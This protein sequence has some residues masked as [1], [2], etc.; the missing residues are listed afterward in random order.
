[1]RSAGPFGL[2]A[3]V[4][5]I[6]LKRQAPVVPNIRPVKAVALRFLNDRE[7]RSGL[8]IERYQGDGTEFDSLKEY[9]TGDDRRAIDW[10]ATARHRKL[11][12]RQNRAERNHQVMIAVDT[13]RLMCEP[14]AGIPKV[15][16]AVNAALILAYVSLRAGDRVGSPPST[17]VRGSSSSRRGACAA[18]TSS[19]RWAGRSTIRTA[20]PTSPSA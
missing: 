13:G 18:S 17:P 16:H 2:I 8:K 11:V 15:D 9:A 20:R 4:A 12:S 6:D 3:T 19:A 1:M 10:K 5:Q 7:F 14:L